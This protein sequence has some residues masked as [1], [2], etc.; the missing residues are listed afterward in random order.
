M[1]PFAK[2]PRQESSL[3]DDLSL[4][5]AELIECQALLAQ[6]VRVDCRDEIDAVSSEYGALF[7]EVEIRSSGAEECLQELAVVEEERNCLIEAQAKAGAV[8]TSAF[9]EV[10]L[11]GREDSEAGA[12]LCEAETGVSRLKLEAIEASGMQRHFTAQVAER[13]RIVDERSLALEKARRAQSTRIQERESS[14]ADLMG[15]LMSKATALQQAIGASR[16]TEGAEDFGVAQH[17]AAAQEAVLLQQ[18]MANSSS[19]DAVASISQQ[20]GT[21]ARLCTEL[22]SHL[23]EATCALQ[24]A[25]SEC[26]RAAQALCSFQEAHAE[27]AASLLVFQQ[28]HSEVGDRLEDSCIVQAEAA[29]DVSNV[30][31]EMS[32]CTKRRDSILTALSDHNT[33]KAEAQSKVVNLHLRQRQLTNRS[34][35]Q[36]RELTRVRQRMKQLQCEGTANQESAGACGDLI[37]AAA[38]TDLDDAALEAVD[39]SHI[40]ARVELLEAHSHAI[41]RGLT[42]ALPPALRVQMISWLQ[43]SDLLRLARASSTLRPE[44]TERIPGLCASFQLSEEALGSFGCGASGRRRPRHSL[45]TVRLLAALSSPVLRGVTGKPELGCRHLDLSKAPPALVRSSNLIEALCSMGKLSTVEYPTRGWGDPTELKRFKDAM[46]A[47][48]VAATSA[49]F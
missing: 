42:T 35:E 11:H 36:T 7:E 17:E 29:E 44:A 49:A 6:A 4:V 1:L 19:M 9:A 34:A 20:A 46:R 47:R 2:R 45:D 14:L 23:E 33:K 21:D 43:L 27:A 8:A 41:P 25:E 15:S 22:R 31:D 28:A 5:E 10:E 13:V 30:G 24:T 40:A 18:M 37:H 3:P 12:R 16:E 39:R 32:E 48:G 38:F 26:S